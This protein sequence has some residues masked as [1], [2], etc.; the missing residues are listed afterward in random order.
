MD[1][2]AGHGA[3]LGG[4]LPT[5]PGELP[6]A[7]RLR[8]LLTW[9]TNDTDP[10]SQ[11]VRSHRSIHP[12]ADPSVLRRAYTIA[13]NMHRGQFRK[14]GEP[15]ITHPLAVAE[16]CADL[17]MDTT[18]L[19]AALLHDTVEDTR[20]T[21]QALAEDFGGEVAHLVDGVT[22]F[23]KAFYGKAAEAETIR[24]MIVAAGKDVRVLIIKLADRLHN[25]RTLGV[26]SAASRERIA[27]KTQEVLV[28]LCD[29]L[30][31]QT[32]KRE[33]DD[34]VLLH[35]EPDEHARIARH[36][37]D[38]PG[39]DAYL[40]DVVAQAKVALRRS[41]VD[42]EV[43]PRPRHLYSIW[44]DTVAGSHTAPFD[45]PRIVI[46]VDGPA[47]D[48]YAALGAVHCRWRPIPGRFKDFIA[49]PK[50]NLYRSL[51]TS[52]C[53]PQDRTVEVLIRTREM[54]RWAEYGIAA[55]FRFPRTAG[56]E[57]AKVDQLGWL[58]RVLDWEQEAPDPAQF[59][60]S[61]RC[62]LAEAQI[63]VVADGRQVVLPAGATP[64]DLAYEL[65]TDRGDHCLAARIN[66]RLAPLSSELE[67]GDVV[68]IFTEN[69]AESGFEATAAPRGPRREWLSFVKSPHAQMQINR[70]FAEHTAPG[71]SIAD[72]VRL[73][74]A[75]IGLALRKRDRGLAS[76][77]PLLRLSEELGYPDLETLLV[78]VFDRAVEPDAVVQQ[79]IDLVDHSR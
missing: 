12:S 65:G 27:R 16:I 11:L 6:L 46:V 9:P 13:E 79:L 7:R 47:T 52:V 44:K 41:R 19:V 32:L 62:D 61:L 33:L 20:Y 48:C 75:T 66:G 15:Y 74:R 51:H 68:E 53:G 37:H 57:S 43:S 55:D 64:V 4:A 5:Q 45:L 49:S 1:V 22:K 69:D 26:R 39:W 77:L 35:L 40:D 70:W 78:A 71:I 38:R 10:V 29:R 30:G 24:K 50:N 23:D 18:T 14:S 42:A 72:K 56:S 3:A 36:V 28:P 21:L 54:H 34:V 76:D 8:S 58:R 73:G 63:Q 31:I 67:E 2:D 60:E 25:M 59:L 17:G